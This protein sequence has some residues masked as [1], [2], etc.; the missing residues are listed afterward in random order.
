[1][2]VMIRATVIVLGVVA[3]SLCV[4]AEDEVR[5]SPEVV[6]V[7]LVNGGSLRGELLLDRDGRV[8]VDLGFDVIEVPRATVARIVTGL[9]DGAARPLER[10]LY[11][12][13]ASR[14]TLS[15]EENIA[16]CAEAVVQ[17]RTPISLGSGFVVHP[18]G[19]VITNQH[20]ISG[21]RR[22]SVT[23]FRQDD[24]GLEKVRFEAVRI[25]AL[26]F[27][28]DL[29]LLHVDT[30]DGTPLASVP[31]AADPPRQGET[32]FAVGSPLGL[33]RTVS[34]GIVSLTERVIRGRLYIQSTAE[35]NP[36]NSG[37][38]LFNLRGEVVG[39]NDLKLAGIGLEG[40]AFA[41]PVG[42]VREFLDH[43]EAFAFDPR[44][45]NAGFRYF[46]PSGGV[47]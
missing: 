38:P 28:R 21:E 13:E 12:I 5:A 6:T 16:R 8:V 27:E 2:Q 17:V 31:L 15:V 24:G 19:Y 33:D 23:V 43:R 45:P 44:N 36:G 40:L 20:V 29:A 26:S 37:G 7:E 1:M 30:E 18:D 25:V 22:I 42:T 41:I 47:Q 11:R 46:D 35:V 9:E 14:S 32:V 34:R 4:A 10:E 39:V 3:V